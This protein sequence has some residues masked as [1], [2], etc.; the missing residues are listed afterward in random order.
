[1][2]F[3]S[4]FKPKSKE[5]WALVKTF[6]HAVSTKPKPGYTKEDGKLYYYLYESDS[7]NRKVE[8]VCNISGMPQESVDEGAKSFD[9]YNETI[10]RWL[11][12][13]VDPSIPRY[14]Q[15]PEEETAAMLSGK[16]TP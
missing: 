7:G 1:M 6:T 9:V 4:H 13:R 11:K 15:I 8:F 3:W 16:I 12:G 2:S 10:Y 5:K 14:N